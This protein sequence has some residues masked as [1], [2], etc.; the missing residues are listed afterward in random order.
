MKSDVYENEQFNRKPMIWLK[1]KN[2]LDQREMSQTCFDVCSINSDAIHSRRTFL[3][4]P[5]LTIF[6]SSAAFSI[7]LLWA[8]ILVLISTLSYEMNRVESL[9]EGIC[10]FLMRKFCFDSFNIDLNH[11]N[12]AKIKCASKL[13]NLLFLKTILLTCPRASCH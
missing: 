11:E 10:D 9:D 12:D 3:N 8:E 1:R 2:V 7:F 5:W 6:S 4:F 13:V